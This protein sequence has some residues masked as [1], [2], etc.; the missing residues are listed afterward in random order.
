M[1]LHWQPSAASQEPLHHA[2]LHGAGLCETALQTEELVI[3][4][5]KNLNDGVLLSALRNWQYLLSKELEMSVVP[6]A[7]DWI[8]F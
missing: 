7:N 8:N 6:S 3:H 1:L 4:I 2:Y 5:S